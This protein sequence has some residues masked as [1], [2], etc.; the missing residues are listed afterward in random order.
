DSPSDGNSIITSSDPAAFAVA[1]DPATGK[2]ALVQFVS[3]WHPNDDNPDDTVT[4]DSNSLSLRVTVTDGDGDYD[5]DDIDISK[6]IKFEDDGPS[7]TAVFNSE[8]QVVHDETAGLQGD[9][10]GGSLPSVFS[11]LTMGS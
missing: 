4:L 9:D 2:L 1:F 6:L 7:V 3:L 10:K 8:F 11:G 5:I